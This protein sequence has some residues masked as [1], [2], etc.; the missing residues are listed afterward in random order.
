MS[1]ELP[2]ILQLDAA[3]NPCSWITY[4]E[5]AYYYAKNL[6]AWTLGDNDYTIYGGENSI[7]GTTSSLNLS[8]IIAVK[9]RINTGALHRPP[10]LTNRVLFRR[11]QNVCAYCG[12]EFKCEDLTRDHVIPRAQQGL[13]KWTN[14]VTACRSCNQFKDDRTPEQAKMKLLYVP[15]APNRSEYLILRNR[16]ILADQMKFLLAQVSKNSR[17]LNPIKLQ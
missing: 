9:G 12:N 1:R 3:G 16:T 5:A 11:D 6:V 15:Y 17:L 13:D 8:T 10:A 4:E 2:L 14:V 7:T